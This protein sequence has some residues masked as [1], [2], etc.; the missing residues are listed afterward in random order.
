MALVQYDPF[1]QLDNLARQVFGSGAGATSRTPRFM[2]LD[3]YKEGN[4]YVL[5]ADLP[6]VDPESIDIDIDNGVLTISAERSTGPTVHEGTSEDG[7]SWVTNERFTG[8]YRRQVTVGDSVDNENVTAD[9]SGGVL[10]VTL[11]LAERAKSRKIS[12]THSEPRK[13]IEAESE[14]ASETGEN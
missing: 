8:T 12:V 14:A 2:P 6:G 3:L 1:T 11:P 9:Y 13:T 5:N 7:T 10:T 4:N